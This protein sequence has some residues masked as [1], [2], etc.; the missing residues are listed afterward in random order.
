M[1]SNGLSQIQF[2]LSN[3][4]LSISATEF[5]PVSD[6]TVLGLVPFFMRYSLILPDIVA[7][8]ASK[9][10]FELF[11]CLASSILG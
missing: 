7:R 4:I 10:G 11:L 3:Q 8:F 2:V 9:K 5:G 1:R 6:S